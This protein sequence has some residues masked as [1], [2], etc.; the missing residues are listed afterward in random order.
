MCLARYLGPM[1]G[2]WLLLVTDRRSVELKKGVIQKQLWHREVEVTRLFTMANGSTMV[3]VESEA[4]RLDFSPTDPMRYT[5]IIHVEVAT[6]RV[7]N[8]ICKYIDG[9]L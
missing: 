7:A 3:S 1:G 8:A 9:H 4:S 6:P 5:K 2:D